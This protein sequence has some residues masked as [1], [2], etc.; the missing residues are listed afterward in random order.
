[1]L[2]NK[3]IVA[4][5]LILG[6]G[7]A[8]AFTPN[9]CT[10]EAGEA[11]GSGKSGLVSYCFSLKG[12]QS[13]EAIDFFMGWAKK[14]KC[15]TSEAQKKK[16]KCAYAGIGEGIVEIETVNPVVVKAVIDAGNNVVH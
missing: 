3:L 15:G 10:R 11:Q 7:A 16:C 1:M 6:M 4:S 2:K 12:V 8:N 13:A 14:H 5:L 9:D